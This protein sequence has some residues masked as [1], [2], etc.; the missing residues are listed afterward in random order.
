M[1]W[2]EPIPAGPERNKW[3]AMPLEEAEDQIR[4][5]GGDV[6]EVVKVAIARRRAEERERQE[7]RTWQ[8]A[9][10]G[11]AVAVIAVILAVISLS[12][13]LAQAYHWIGRS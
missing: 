12:L 2:Y 1:P 4:R 5:R 6:S 7:K 11:L 8:I 10:A 9:C 13:S 3:K